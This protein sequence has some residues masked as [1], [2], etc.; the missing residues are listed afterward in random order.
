MAQVKL[1][2]DFSVIILSTVLRSA[3]CYRGERSTSSAQS[4]QEAEA[5]VC[6][7]FS[8]DPGWAL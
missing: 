5:V 6:N 7:Y 4:S 1:S 2:G 3:V 8:C